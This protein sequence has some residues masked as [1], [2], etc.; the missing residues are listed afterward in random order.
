MLHHFLKVSCPTKTQIDPQRIAGMIS[1]NGDCGGS[2]SCKY[3]D[4]FRNRHG[5]SAS[6]AD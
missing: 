6:R 4:K 1:S 5:D 2:Q 3:V